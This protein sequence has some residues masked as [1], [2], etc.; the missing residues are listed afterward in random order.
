MSA[1]VFR[2]SGIDPVAL[3]D[4]IRATLD[5]FLADHPDIEDAEIEVAE[6]VET[7]ASFG[8]TVNGIAVEVKLWMPGA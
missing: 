3:A 1:P 6:H 2:T 5:L 4:C 8:L 7:D